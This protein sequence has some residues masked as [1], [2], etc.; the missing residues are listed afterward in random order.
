MLEKKIIVVCFKALRRNSL[1]ETEDG[2]EN[3]R[4]VHNGIKVKVCYL[5][6]SSLEGVAPGYVKLYRKWGI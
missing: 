3:F 2:Y 4:I 5:P 6:N 1:R